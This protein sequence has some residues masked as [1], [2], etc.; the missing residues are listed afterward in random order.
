MAK[1]V[2]AY[3]TEDLYWDYAA[4]S[5]FF[6]GGQTGLLREAVRSYIETHPL[7]EEEKDMV[8]KLKA[9][10]IANEN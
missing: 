7:T 2:G 1:N 8:Q 9:K 5:F 4:K 3:F 10:Q 6:P